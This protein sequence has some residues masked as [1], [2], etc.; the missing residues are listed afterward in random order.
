LI[1]VTLGE[2]RLTTILLL[3]CCLAPHNPLMVRTFVFEKAS[4]PSCHC[5]AIVET[6]EGLV[7]S[8]FGGTDEGKDVVVPESGPA[9]SSYPT[10]IRSRDGNAH[11]V[12]TLKQKKIGHVLIDPSAL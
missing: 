12:Y 9:E 4:F 6:K 5:S 11:V 7:T 3:A 1:E 8:W 2:D 10:V